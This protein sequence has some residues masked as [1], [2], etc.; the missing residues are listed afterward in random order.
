MTEL[1]SI[2]GSSHSDSGHTS[3]SSVSH[4]QEDQKQEPLRQ[5]RHLG[6]VW[7]E[8]LNI[9]MPLMSNETVFVPH[10]QS[11]KWSYLS[12]LQAENQRAN[13]ELKQQLKMQFKL[14]LEDRLRPRN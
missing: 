7:T 10:T 9:V 13:E 2:T 6:K 8:H 1:F 4:L 3:R 11:D 12:S 14:G 5:S